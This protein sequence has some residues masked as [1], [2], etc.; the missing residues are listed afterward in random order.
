MKTN[1]KYDALFPERNA[2]IAGVQIVLR[3]FTFGQM[4]KVVGALGSIMEEL[5]QIDLDGIDISE[6][7]NLSL[8][9][10]VV[11]S[12]A[13]LIAVNS[14]KIVSILVMATG[15]P[16]PDIEDLPPDEGIKLCAEVFAVNKRFFQERLLPELKRRMPKNP[17]K[18]AEKE[19]PANPSD[20]QE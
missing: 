6:S 2:E 14:D 7:G 3:P 4:P 19:E 18:P 13:N 5:V 10:D 12:I 1:S 15:W 17:V 9:G 11:R 16:A 8:D 20:G